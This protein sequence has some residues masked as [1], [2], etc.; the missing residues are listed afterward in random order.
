M[1]QPTNNGAAVDGSQKEQ[2][3]GP[4]ISEIVGLQ[5]VQPSLDRRP[6]NVSTSSSSILSDD[7]SLASGHSVGSGMD[8]LPSGVGGGS[9]GGGSADTAAGPQGE[10]RHPEHPEGGGTKRTLSTEDP[11]VGEPQPEQ[12]PSAGGQQLRKACDLCTKVRGRP[13]LCRLLLCAQSFASGTNTVHGTLQVHIYR[14]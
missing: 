9:G 3:G 5:E 11:R 7:A 14:S 8:L 4:L 2:S 6:S 13:S 10:A 12:Q 1:V